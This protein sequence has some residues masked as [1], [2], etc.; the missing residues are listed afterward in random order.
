MAAV[1]SRENAQQDDLTTGEMRA[2]VVFCVENLF[3]V[4]TYTVL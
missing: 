1:T 2:V 3:T 4:A